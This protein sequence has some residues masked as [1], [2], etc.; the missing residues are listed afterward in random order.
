MDI[1]P[2]LYGELVGQED[3]ICLGWK[4]QQ[5]LDKMYQLRGMVG[6]SELPFEALISAV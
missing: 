5:V 1:L 2:K 6:T 3:I 4:H